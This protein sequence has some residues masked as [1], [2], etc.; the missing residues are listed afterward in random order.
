M[1][2]KQVT[3]TKF[4]A[5]DGMEFGTRSECEAREREVRNLLEHDVYELRRKKYELKN[6]I[7][8]ARINARIAWLD[9][10]KLKAEAR[11]AMSKSEYCK[12]MANYWAY[13]SA[14]NSKRRT[15]FEVR[16]RIS[17]SIDSLYMWFGHYKKKSSVA[18]LERRRRSD[19][20]R[21][22]HTPDR[23]RTPHKIRVSKPPHPARGED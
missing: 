18:R 12:L 6:A 16:R 19:A 2:T 4:I 5:C 3:V 17:A 8:E 22:E 7:N 21:K 13:T 20:W 15:L 1:T 23:W 10:Q 11:S 9:A 14:Y